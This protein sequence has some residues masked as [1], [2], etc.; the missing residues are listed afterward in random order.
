[1]LALSLRERESG[2]RVCIV[3]PGSVDTPMLRHEAATGC[4]ALNFLGEPMPPEKV[5]DVVASQLDKPRL[6]ASLPRHDRWLVKLVNANPRLLLRLR[7]LLE[8]LPSPDSA[9]VATG[10]PCRR[11]GAVVIAERS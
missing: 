1:M 2:V 11:C 9:S 8:R 7:P 5:A 4:S 6:E 10:T 3:N